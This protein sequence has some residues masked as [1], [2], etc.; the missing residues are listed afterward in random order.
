MTSGATS[1]S[2]EEIE[3]LVASLTTGE[4]EPIVC[5]GQ[6]VAFWAARFGLGTW[7]SRDLDLVASRDEAAAVSGKLAG[8]IRYPSPY[9][10]TVLT[11]VIRGSWLGRVL[12][13]ECLSNIP[14]LE[15][16]PDEISVQVPVNGGTIRI[17][18]PVALGLAK[19][20]ALRF[21]NQEG[22]KDAAHL[23]VSLQAGERWLAETARANPRRALLL[24]HRWYRAA[25]VPGNRRILKEQ[26]VDW[27]SVV[28]LPELKNLAPEQPQVRRFLSDQWPRLVAENS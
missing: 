12:E 11:A 14:G 23:Q 13:V 3:P 1:W 7:V 19:L 27:T 4:L 10:M 5:G 6:A 21:F 16:E 9:E 17:L 24:I 26:Q 8:S 25:R 18:H 2:W 15:T 22:R 28:P 20:H